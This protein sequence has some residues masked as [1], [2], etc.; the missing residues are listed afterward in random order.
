MRVDHTAGLLFLDAEFRQEVERSLTEVSQSVDILAGYAK[1]SAMEWLANHLAGK[2]INVTVVVGWT[3]KDLVDGASDLEAYKFARERNWRFGIRPELHAKIFWMDR[4]ELLV[5]SANLTSRGLHIDIGGN[6][7]AG[8]RITPTNVDKTKLDQ[9]ITKSLWLDD[10]LFKDIEKQIEQAKELPALE[11][12]NLSW[13]Q[14]I[15]EKLSQMNDFL[16]V[17]DLLMTDPNSVVASDPEVTALI[18]HDQSLLGG[19]YKEDQPDQLTQAL[20]NTR[21]INWIKCFLLEQKDNW[22]R[23]GTVSAALHDVLLDDPKPYRRDVKAL[24]SNLF[25]W[26][27]YAQMPEFELRKHRRT[28]SIHLI[29]DRNDSGDWF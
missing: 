26:I 25:A 24:Q 29:S 16:W 10:Q 7:E 6:I 1:I 20:R 8:V 17:D 12:A 11:E 9:L 27:E 2:E 18:L 14:S 23:F 3:P 19:L 13:P 22:A 5:G 15:E 21:V 4:S 28:T